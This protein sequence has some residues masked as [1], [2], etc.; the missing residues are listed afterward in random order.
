MQWVLESL[1]PAEERFII[2]NQPY[3]EFNLS[4][5][6]DIL[7]HQTPLSGIHSA[8]VHAQHDWVAVAA[9]DMPFLTKAHWQTLL[10][11][12]KNTSAVVV[13]SETGLEPLA[14]FYHKTLQH[15]IEEQLQQNQ[16]AIQVFLQSID[17]K[18]L[19]AQTL[20]VPKHTFDN[21]NRPHDIVTIRDAE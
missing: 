11:Y 4:V 5:Y 15:D 19:N 14:A 2:A 21:I 12:C 3:D 13:E 7:P 9:C 17:V 10:P 18:T 8:L 20:N 6:S 1:E 16:K